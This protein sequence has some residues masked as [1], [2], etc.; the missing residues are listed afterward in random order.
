MPRSNRPKRSKREEPEEINVAAVRFGSRRTE[1]KRG[2]VYVVQP[3]SGRNAEE[4]K[5]WICP[6]CHL[7]IA[8]GTNH[9]VAWDEV[10]GVDTRRHFHN[11]CWSK[12]QGSLL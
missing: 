3:T 2:I 4:D 8:Q 10:R 6:N 5:S 1:T 7:N 9:L 12:F 11:T